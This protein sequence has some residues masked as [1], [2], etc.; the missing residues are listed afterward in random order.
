MAQSA[1]VRDVVCTLRHQIAKIEGR[2]AETLEKRPGGL[3]SG[4]AAAAHLV[5]TGIES[6]DRALGGGFPPA[7]LMELYGTASRDAGAV[8]GFA[9]ALVRLLSNRVD[10]PLL[11]IGNSEIFREAG[12]PYAPGLAA[13]FGLRPDGLLVAEAERLADVLWI[14]EEAARVDALRAILLEIRGSP[15]ALDLT[16]TRRLHRRA[17]LSGFP[18][19]LLREAGEAQPTAAPLRLMV[20]PAPAAPR[21]TLAGPLPGSIGPP[22]FRVT[23]SKSRTAIPASF[24]LEWVDDVFRERHEHVATDPVP[25]VSAS[26]GRPAAAAAI[27][28]GMAVERLG[29]RPAAGFQP[30]GEQ[31]PTHRRAGRQG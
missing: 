15:H 24:T 8:S 31:Y 2:L 26:S 23:V 30:A 28:K 3:P 5:R 6:F 9:L 22:A 29:A 11:W 17:L 12:R 20:A 25:L 19:L 14:A 13:V 27:G 7:G 4:P 1:R 10:A 18:L 16:V 21:L